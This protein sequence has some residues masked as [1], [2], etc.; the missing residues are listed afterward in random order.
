MESDNQIQSLS[1]QLELKLKYIKELEDK[2]Q[3]MAMKIDDLR[4]EKKEAKDRIEYLEE[5]NIKSVNV[6]KEKSKSLRTQC[7]LLK[8]SNSA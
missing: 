2:S 4:R 3:N 8:C 6:L 5:V 1:S 7:E